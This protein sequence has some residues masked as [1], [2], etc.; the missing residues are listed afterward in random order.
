[1]IKT[2]I[3][4]ERFTERGGS[5]SVVG[6]LASLWPGGSLF[7]PIID[8]R[9]VP[10]SARGLTKSVSDLQ[11]FYRG[12]GNYSH[13]VPF[14]PRAMRSFDLAGADV[15]LASH[16]AFAN[17][18]RPPAGIPMV[19]YVH[20]PARWMWDEDFLN[21]RSKSVT[22][23]VA[24]RAF[25]KAQRKAD[26]EAAQRATVLVANSTVVANRIRDWW[27]REPELVFPPVNVDFFSPDP[28][29]PREDFFLMA[30]RHLSH[31]QAEGAVLAASIANVPLLIV[32][33]SRGIA[34]AKSVAGPH[35][36]FV[37]HV[38]DDE[39]RDLYRRCRAFVVPSVENFAIM[40]IEAQAC[41]APVLGINRGGLRDSV[42]PKVTGILI[43]LEDTRDDQVSAF[44]VAMSD[45]DRTE[46]DPWQI[47]RNAER[48]EPARFRSRMT[49][50]VNSV[51]N[52]GS[53]TS[54]PLVSR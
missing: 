36:R 23:T 51:V 40:P 20:T 14:L 34:L 30:A 13:L 38:S 3:V 10:P 17:R 8:D 11:R 32:G 54:Q 35:V 42:V 43:P 9:F 21:A 16:H 37:E 41:G 6:Q 1:M 19:S 48:F 46:F 5:E 49:S 15:V 53:S 52:V 45:F 29:V 22:S 26:R 33:P 4:H 31:K 47:R 27:G 12:D 18:A 44:A 25:A 24:L 39:L 50:I 7:A 28:S 2:A